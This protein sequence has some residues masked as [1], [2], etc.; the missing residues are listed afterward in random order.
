MSQHDMVLDDAGGAAFLADVNDAIKA[1]ASNSVGTSAPAT[2]YAGQTWI[3]SAATP[4]VEKRWTG[5]AWVIVGYINTSTGLWTP[6]NADSLAVGDCLKTYRRTAPPKF[7]FP[8][9]QSLLRADYPD[10]FA[11]IGTDHGAA[12]AT[13]F[14]LPDERGR[15]SIGR[16]DMGGTAANRITSAGGGIAGAT[17]G[18]SGGGQSSS[19]LV[20]H[21]H[22]YTRTIIDPEGAV[23]PEYFTYVQKLNGG[24]PGAM[25]VRYENFGTVG[26]GSGASFSILP[27]GIVCNWI[28]KVLP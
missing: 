13:H 25:G 22:T 16:D 12:D 11:E 24:D 21:G 1:L 9:G 8:C 26:A 18:A 20:A 3:D 23:H 6:A 14:N 5:S 17:L 19:A 7:L 15:F 28:M 4:W 2:R 27:P 10:L